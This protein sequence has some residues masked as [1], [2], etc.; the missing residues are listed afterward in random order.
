MHTRLLTTLALAWA[1]EGKD[2]TA[3]GGAEP[4]ADVS[5]AFRVSSTVPE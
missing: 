3:S 2:D 4:D 1:W 5:G